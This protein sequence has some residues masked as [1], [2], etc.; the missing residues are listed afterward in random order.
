MTVEK[1]KINDISAASYAWASIVFHCLCEIVIQNWIR[2]NSSGNFKRVS[3]YCSSSLRSERRLKDRQECS[4]V[5][6]ND[7]FE[8]SF[9]VKTWHKASLNN[10]YSKPYDSRKEGHFE[11]EKF[12][13]QIFPHTIFSLIWTKFRKRKRLNPL[14]A[15]WQ[16][17]LSL[18]HQCLIYKSHMIATTKHKHKARKL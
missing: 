15:T 13:L 2:F 1:I 9:S 7:Q 5:G 3:I 12:I 10:I 18:F 16:N 11:G 8:T 6:Q 4:K 17:M 14:F